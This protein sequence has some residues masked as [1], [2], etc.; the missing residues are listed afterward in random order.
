VTSS[1]KAKME[2]VPLGWSDSLILSCEVPWTTSYE[3][4]IYLG[5]TGR[6]ASLPVWLLGKALRGC[7]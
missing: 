6:M 3:E 5:R 2:F 7:S 1:D 4:A